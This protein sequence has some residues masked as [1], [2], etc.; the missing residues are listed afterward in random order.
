MVAE[1]RYSSL[2][3][4]G[5]IDGI[6]AF[7]HPYGCSQ[8]GDDLENTQKILAALILLNIPMLPEFWFLV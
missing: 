5:I 8:L 2:I 3:S 6:Y 1:E 4:V 7:T